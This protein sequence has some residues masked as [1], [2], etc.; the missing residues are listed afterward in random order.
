MPTSVANA[1]PA[2]TDVTHRV[3][4]AL[5]LL[6]RWMQAPETRRRVAERAG[7]TPLRGGYTLLFG[8]ADNGPVR[9]SVMA[10]RLGLDRSTL[11][12]Q[13]QGLEEQGLIA[14][15]ADPTDQRAQVITVTESGRDALG[16][17]CEARAQ[18]V[19]QLLDGWETAAIETLA[20]T[21]D[22]FADAA[23]RDRG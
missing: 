20:Q 14:R 9:L 22:G 17:L 3:A 6:G 8:L 15:V 13:A 18:L 16:R 11:T 7:L 23:C 21:L 4:S 19:A 1:P 5:T 2:S 10:D 12:P